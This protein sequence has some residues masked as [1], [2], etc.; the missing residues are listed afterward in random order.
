MSFRR[1]NRAEPVVGARA[2]GAV[3][4]VGSGRPLGDAMTAAAGFAY[5]STNSLGLPDFTLTPEQVE[6]DQYVDQIGWVGFYVQIK[7]MLGAM[8]PWVV[9][10]RQGTEWVRTEDP[11]INAM[12]YMIQPPSRTTASL[13]FRSLTLQASI[14][15][16]AFFPA[17]TED[18]GLVFDIA[19][20]QQMRRSQRGEE[21]FS[22]ATRQDARP[23]TVGWYDY[24]LDRLRRHWIPDRKWPDQ[25]DPELSTVLTEMRLYESTTL[26]LLRSSQ[27]RMLMNG[28]LYIPTDPGEAA[29]DGQ[30]SWVEEASNFSDAGDT[31][32]ETPAGGSLQQLIADFSAFGARAFRDHRGTDVASRMPYPFPHFNKPEMIELGRPMS[33]ESLNALHEV[34]LAASR[35][36]HIPTQF[37]VSGEGSTNHWNDAELRR[38]LHERAVYPELEPNNE[39]WTEMAL[40]PLL[41]LSR[42]GGMV[43]RDGDPDDYRLACDTS[44]LD[45]KSDS[46]RTLALA[47]ATGVASR[48]WLAQKLGV[49][50]SELLELPSNVNDWERWLYSKASATRAG[51]H[52]FEDFPDQVNQSGI[53]NEDVGALPGLPGGFE[54]AEV[55]VEIDEVSAS[56]E[57]SAAAALD[58]ILAA[59]KS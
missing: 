27:S 1:L 24:P 53:I 42:A 31:S 25:A 33:E 37:L 43:L 22:V 8:C 57:V 38:A 50:E 16:H 52:T 35:G 54:V 41:A 44:V 9:E 7:A 11:R 5:E 2:A 17:H 34:V 14:A 48:S 21:W 58:L 23:G 28:L 20:P 36:L 10:E 12:A 46:L 3:I 39:F 45:I 56:A 6:I 15:E 40:R 29:S 59:G 4:D 19:H 47:H 13:R 18:R 49:P 32:P 26:D 30:G 55:E 51:A